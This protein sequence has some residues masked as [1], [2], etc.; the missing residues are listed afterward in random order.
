MVFELWTRPK[1]LISILNYINS[2]ETVVQQYTKTFTAYFGCFKFHFHRL[3]SSNFPTHSQC[4][5]VRKQEKAAC[6]CILWCQASNKRRRM[7]GVK[8]HHK[9]DCCFLQ[10]TSQGA[11]SWCERRR[12]IHETNGKRNIRLVPSRSRYFSGP[13]LLTCFRSERLIF[14]SESWGHSFMEDC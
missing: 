5:R 3:C 2:L 4:C 6:A 7:R 8:Q 11:T 12:Y 14:F 1:L 10:H 9:P 13:S